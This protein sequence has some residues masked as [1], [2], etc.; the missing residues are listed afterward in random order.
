MNF[1]WIASTYGFAAMAVGFLL[2]GWG[3]MLLKYFGDLVHADNG[4]YS[5]IRLVGVGFF[6]AGA[7]LL[8]VRT[9]HDLS[10]PRRLCGWMWLTGV[11]FARVL[12]EGRQN[13]SAV[14]A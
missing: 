13:G 10:L 4:S 12:I 9:A 7:V 3:P 6:L 8:A 11:T 14:R 1:R 5:L 2:M